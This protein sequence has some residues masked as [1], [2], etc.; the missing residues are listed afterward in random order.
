MSD[1]NDLSGKIG[2][3]TT[4]FKAAISSIN[5][6]I[7]VVESGFRASAAA[8]GDWSKSASGL[9]SRMKALSAEIELQQKKTGALKSEYEK[10]KKEKGENSR[11]AQEL[12]IKLNK[13]NETLGKM[14]IELKG[15]VTSLANMGKEEKQ[16][17]DK[18]EDLDKSE[19]KA[20]TSTNQ[21]GSAMKSLTGHLKD[22]GSGLA[23]VI[24]H[25]AKLAAGLAV[26]LAA[27][28]TG[29]VVAIGALMVKSG[30]WADQFATLSGV[31]GVSTTRLQELDYIGKKLDVDLGTMTGSMSK[32][33]RSLSSAK[34]GTGPAA[35]A[36]AALGVSIRDSSGELRDSEDIWT[37][38]IVA[39]GGVSNETERD[40]LAM[41]IFGK[42]AM[43]LNPLI[44]AGT[45]KL[46]A[47]ADEANRVGAVM[48]EK[49]VEALD[50]FSD[51]SAAMGNT[52]KGITGTLAAAF[53]PA[54]NAAFTA[55][56]N[57]LASPAV[58]K[59]LENLRSG[60]S[61][62]ATI[63]AVSFKT[64]NPLFAM[65]QGIGAMAGKEG[66]LRTIADGLGG[67]AGIIPRL[68][69]G[70]KAGG[71]GGML[72][73]LIPEGGIGGI[74]SGLGG[75]IGKVLSGMLTSFAAQPAKLLKIGLDII[76]GL[77]AGLLAA[78]PKLLPVFLQLI[79]SLV[80]FITT[81]L[82]TLLQLGLTV[83]LQ[84]AMGIMQAIPQLIPVVLQ[85]ITSFV[86]FLITN[87][88]MIITAALQLIITLANGI[89]QALPTLIPTILGIIPVIIMTLLENLPL[90]ITAAL[91][92]IMALAQGI[93]AALPILIPEIPKIVQTIIDVITKNLP[94]VIKMALT[95]IT[96]LVAAIV[97]NLPMIGKAAIDIITALLNGIVELFPELI[98]AAGDIITTI[99][100]AI[101]DLI[102]TVLT[103]G[104]DIVE[105][106]WKGIKDAWAQLLVDMGGIIK[107]LPKW[108]QKLLGIASESKVFAEIGRNMAAGLGSGFKNSYKSIRDQIGKAVEGLSAQASMTVS[109]SLGGYGRQ[110]QPAP[111]PIYVTVQANVNNE[112]DYYRL[113]QRVGEQIKR[114]R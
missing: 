62:I 38:A 45:D 71:I 34:D 95:L 36:Y 93:I 32:M 11:A 103:V 89:A 12:Q 96:T 52:I 74:I 13:E 24:G 19:K 97:T 101:G 60:I 29:A 69:A 113:A 23:N 70:F 53:A 31:T 63:I 43:E 92:L 98:T 57:F 81:T 8:L 83:V 25:V 3:D 51:S 28:A 73:S 15:T 90:L 27:A 48:S 114:G 104:R 67:L 21:F 105:G 47:L 49:D 110:L 94:L 30:E 1:Q 64:G 6:D 5:R 106:I 50:Q 77:A 33:I 87:L 18:T 72:K 102:P 66:I 108:V 80:N 65:A 86:Q 22:V 111:A 9:E 68:Q 107:G 76:Q 88:P 56:N 79:T 20:T 44:T 37:D 59:G 35:E 78:I 61:R 82:P 41:T 55:L 26:G 109:G 14:Q 40:T 7:R 99:V 85:M 54:L 75:T 17:K 91:N 46:K 58:H 39:L 16:D 42:S 84:L 4:D 112:I 100:D 2:L 10:V